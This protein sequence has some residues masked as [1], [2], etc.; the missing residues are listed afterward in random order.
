MDLPVGT[1]SNVAAVTNVELSSTRFR[2]AGNGFVQR[3]GPDRQAMVLDAVINDERVLLTSGRRQPANGPG[4]SI[5]LS[6]GRSARRTFVLV[7]SA[8]AADEVVADAD[9]DGITDEQDNC[10][11][12]PNSAQ[13]DADR[14]GVGDSCDTCPDTEEHALNNRAGCSLEQLCPCDMTP[15]GDLWANQRQYL[16]CV[17]R[18][19]RDLRLEWRL[20]ATERIELIR[21]A[22]KSSCGRVEVAMR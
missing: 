14:D 3:I 18:A 15:A 16:Q 12:A 22:A 1:V 6:S 20:S 9:G 10:P 5:V 21:H 17:A 11:S 7:I 19:T 2:V 4:F 8:A 13:R